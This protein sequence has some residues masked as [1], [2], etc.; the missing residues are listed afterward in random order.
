MTL[1]APLFGC[2]TEMT[3]NRREEKFSNVLY[4]IEPSLA[5]QCSYP[6]GIATAAAAN[7]DRPI[8]QSK[9]ELGFLWKL[10]GGGLGKNILL[11]R[12]LLNI[13]GKL[14]K[15]KCRFN[16][17]LMSPGKPA[18]LGP[19]LHMYDQSNVPRPVPP[20]GVFAV[21]PATDAMFFDLSIKL[22]T[23]VRLC[24][25]VES[26]IMYLQ[27]EWYEMQVIMIDNG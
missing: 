14:T 2:K 3:R 4:G 23:S 21:S 25:F 1:R 5:V 12:E 13:L 18:L 8:N 26:C 15:T 20:S 22:N 27:S 7:S 6:R 24:M 19:V 11:Y 10:R 16:Y 17:P 9:Y